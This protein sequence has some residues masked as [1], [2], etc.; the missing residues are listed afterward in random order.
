LVNGAPS[1][2]LFDPVR[3]L[4]F[5]L[6]EIE[7]AIFS[8]WAN[9]RI[10][11]VS[12][13]LSA[14]GMDAEE[15]D[16]AFGRTLEF[17]LTNSLT[18]K[19]LGDVVLTYKQQ[20]EAARKAWWKWMLDNY[21]FIRIPLV[22]P[23]AFLERTLPNVAP[24]WSRESLTFFAL[25]ALLGLFM[26]SRQWDAFMASF[27]YFFSWQGLLAYGAGLF[28]VKIIHE[29]G[30]AY[31]ATRFGAHVPT[32]GVSLMV[33]MP[34]LYTDT[35]GAWRLRSR[36]ERLMI[37]CA[38]VTAELMVASISTL[39]WVLLPDGA[40]RSVFF[41]LATSSWI[42]S[43]GINLNPFMRFDGYYVL[44]DLLGV[45]NLQPR[46]FAL[47]RWKLRELLFDLGDPAPE[48]MPHRL[49][50]GLV[51]YAWMTW[52]YRLVLFIGIALLVYHLFFKLLGI[53]LFL[54]EI[55]V[56]VAKPVVSEFRVWGAMRERIGGTRRGRLWPWILSG[57]IILAFLPLDRHVSA[58]A[59]LA[60]IGAAPVVS[61]DPARIDRILVTNDQPVKAGT[62]LM[63][64]S[65]PELQSA[66]AQARVRI[67][68][69]QAQY[70]RA[71]GDNRD[72]S[73]R[74]VIERE[75]IREQNALAGLERRSAKLVLRAPISGVVADIVPDFHV[76]RWL[77]GSEVLARI[78]TPGDYDVQAY[79]GE[80][81]IDRV[82]TG[83]LGRFVPDD[84]ALPSR[85]IK[86]V[87]R[88][89]SAVEHLDQPLLA[90]LNGGGIAVDVD[91]KTE[92]MRPR[93]TFYK[94]RLLAQKGNMAGL[95][96]PI[97][98]TIIL[99]ADAQSWALAWLGQGMDLFRQEF[100]LTG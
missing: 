12:E 35:T 80:T 43:L 73:N 94:A 3:H 74:Q 86:L 42:M 21:L 30:H 58:P 49:R 89:L 37:D 52:I 20:R 62:V 41:V 36:K 92:A 93:K 48:E 79:V 67:A 100:S 88:S 13:E 90:S 7:F 9:G 55:A 66:A 91:T 26:V 45:P 64:L 38:G 63:E 60:P 32:M 4:F 84:A 59:V 6:G 28:A 22:R 14:K 1:W 31:T 96:Q 69:L 87:E 2:T 85:R 34:M 71:A 70:D 97:R 39:I 68:Q 11:R 19:P 24:L 23:A 40:L 61:G 15:I 33:L 8:N 56:F 83:A 25:L 95:M 46:A 51:I 75:L 77:N 99:K 50:K 98:G 5:Q 53:I 57:L 81:D 78:V 47:G 10:D 16:A 76:G 29:L 17:S 44:S 27:L 82:N 18:Q 72:L 65:A 54:V